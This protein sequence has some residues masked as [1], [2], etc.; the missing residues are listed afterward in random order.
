AHAWA[1]GA[2]F[3]G[4]LIALRPSGAELQAGLATWGGL[5]VLG[6]ALCYAVAAV[7][8]RLLSRTDRS[9]SLVLTMMV[10]MALGGG[11]VAWPHWQPVALADWPLLAALA[12]T[13]FV[14]QLALTEAFRHGQASIVAP[15]EYSALAWGLGLD[16][17][18]WQ[19]LPGPHT[20]LGAAI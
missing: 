15:F 12:L 1:I 7:A 8:G 17:L 2:G 10:A 6:A 19:T 20:W 3:I 4:V 16:W 11:A 14:G 9:E 13:G 18:I 5:A